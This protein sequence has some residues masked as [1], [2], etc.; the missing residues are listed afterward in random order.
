[1]RVSVSCLLIFKDASSFGQNRA[2][3][4]SAERHAQ[5]GRQFTSAVQSPSQVGIHMLPARLTKSH[6][7]LVEFG[8]VQ[9]IALWPQSACLVDHRE[10]CSTTLI[11]VRVV[12][13]VQKPE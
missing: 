4:R 10:R 13:L 3:S 7:A 11:G 8:F 6:V 12:K 2:W 5:S 9:Y 1:M